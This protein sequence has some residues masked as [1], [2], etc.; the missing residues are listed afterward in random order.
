ML[1]SLEISR[2]LS[3]AAMAMAAMSSLL[4]GTFVGVY[5]KPSQK[6]GAMVMAFGT[7]AL[8]QALALQLA[9]EGAERLIHQARLSGLHSW[10][11]VAGGFIAG[12]I[13]YI[14]APLHR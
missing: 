14:L 11:W 8:I 13:I 5:A 12:G 10:L 3:A 2:V 6:I 1:D 7:G 9:F 4:I